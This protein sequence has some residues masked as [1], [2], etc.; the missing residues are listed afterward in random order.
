[1]RILH[2]NSL[3]PPHIVGG[4]E[5]SVAML[6]E[7]QAEMGHHVA[8]A[9]ISPNGRSREMRN[10]VSVYRMPHENDF[11]MEDWPKYSQAEREAA[12]FKQ[13]FNFAIER[14][15][16]A[17]IDD[18]QPDL[19]NTHSLVDV[20]TRT[21]L[22]AHRRGVPIV[23]TLREYDLL[24]ATSSLF[25]DAPCRGRHLKCRAL[26]FTK[27]FD[28]RCVGAVTAVGQEV[29]KRHLEAGFFAHVPPELRQVI[30]N[31]AE[32]EGVDRAYVRPPRPA[33]RPFTFGFLGRISS[34]KGVDTLL[35]ACRALPA[36]GWR[37]VIGGATQTSLDTE[38]ALAKGLP[39]EFAGFVQPKAFFEGI[40]VLVVPSLWAEPLGRTV[41]EAYRV[42]VPVIG[43]DSGGVAELIDDPAWLA[44]PGDVEALAALMRRVLAAGPQG[45]PPPSRF[46]RVV[47]ATRGEAVAARFLSLYR[48]TQLQARPGLAKAAPGPAPVDRPLRPAPTLSGLDGLT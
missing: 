24:C 27:A 6:A 33:D 18:F 15:F 37:L 46:S 5:R 16:A 17:V 28:Q 20:S 26:T 38:K 43:S 21:W 35:K 36:E 39:V 32:I 9:C 31:T 7:A 34:E 23:H 11:W 45:L 30:W 3:Y 1:M 4:A 12:K 8:A 10:G 22:A 2:L 19:V 25:R 44:P 14:N 40:D 48:A 29:L 42:G 41:L 13:Q 47:E